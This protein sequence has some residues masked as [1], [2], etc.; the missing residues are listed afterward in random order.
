[1]ESGV[2]GRPSGAWITPFLVTWGLRP[3]LDSAAPLGANN[4]MSSM[5]VRRTDTHGEP[6]SDLSICS[7]GVGRTCNPSGSADFD[8]RHSLFDRLRLPNTTLY[9]QHSDSMSS[10]P[11]TFS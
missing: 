3:R 10:R 7:K 6:C 1:M 2:I 5:P 4:T 9:A 8:I 11:F